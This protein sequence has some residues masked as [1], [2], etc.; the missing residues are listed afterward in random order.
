[1]T[2]DASTKSLAKVGITNYG[3][4]FANNIEREKQM[5]CFAIKTL[6]KIGIDGNF[7][8]QIK[9]ICRKIQS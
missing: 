8:S 1:M 3:I 6:N 9:G 7:L 2:C 4:H 5:T